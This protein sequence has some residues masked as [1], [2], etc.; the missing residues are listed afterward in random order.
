MILRLILSN[1][2]YSFDK[3]LHERFPKTVFFGV[4]S[5]RVVKVHPHIKV[6]L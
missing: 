6:S 2:S 3:S 1:Y 5:F 4:S